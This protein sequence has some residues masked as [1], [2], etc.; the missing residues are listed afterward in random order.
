MRLLCWPQYR[1]RDSGG[2]PRANFS[3][4]YSH[5]RCL[6]KLDFPISKTTFRGFRRLVRRANPGLI[7]KTLGLW[8]VAGFPHKDWRAE[9]VI[10]LKE[11]GGLEFEDYESC[12]VCGHEHIRF[13]HILSHSDYPTCVRAGVICAEN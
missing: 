11:E 10:D 9:E 1:P 5:F 6:R 3:R 13:V 4:A 2:T 12:E 8:A 7:M